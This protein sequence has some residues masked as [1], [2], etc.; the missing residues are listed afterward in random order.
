MALALL[1]RSAA[2]HVTGAAAT[3]AAIRRFWSASAAV[4]AAAPTAMR[5]SALRVSVGD[6]PSTTLRSIRATGAVA[7]PTASLATC[8]AVG[9]VAVAGVGVRN[10]RRPRTAVG[11]AAPSAP[12]SAAFSSTLPHRRRSFGC[13][14]SLA[15]EPTPMAP[16]PNAP[17]VSGSARFRFLIPDTALSTYGLAAAPASPSSLPISTPAVFASADR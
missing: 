5:G 14:A 11:A 2:S 15:S 9:G 13:S 8:G 7:D 3:P 17:A 16:A 1:M 10:S 6:S 12:P 4:S